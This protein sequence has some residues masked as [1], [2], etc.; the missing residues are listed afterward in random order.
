MM[1]GEGSSIFLKRIENISPINIVNKES[2]SPIIKKQAN[3]L[4]Q[5]ASKIVEDMIGNKESKDL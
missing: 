2:A 1:M 3:E 5:K 4:A